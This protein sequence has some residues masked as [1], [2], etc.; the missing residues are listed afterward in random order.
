MVDHDLLVLVEGSFEKNKKY[1][2][3]SSVCI[4]DGGIYMYVYY[5]SSSSL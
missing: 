3:Y 2:A 1:V 4:L 5:D